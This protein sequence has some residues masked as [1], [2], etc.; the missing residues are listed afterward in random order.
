MNDDLVKRLKDILEHA[1]FS[2]QDEA[3]TAAKTIIDAIEIIEKY[4]GRNPA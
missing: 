1:S 2:T 3:L 4:F